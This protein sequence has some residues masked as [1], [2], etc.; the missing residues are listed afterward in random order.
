MSRRKSAVSMFG[1]LAADPAPETDASP[2]PEAPPKRRKAGV[3]GATERTMADIREEREKLLRAVNETQ[4]IVA[5]DPETIDPSPVTDRLPDDDSGSF[6][7]LKA[8]LQSEGQK[9]PILVR[10]HPVDSDRYQI[11]FG[12]RRTRALRE[13]G[14]TVL[15]QVLDY[16]DRDLLVAQGIENA[17]R[18]DLTWIEKALFA[19]RM[20]NAGL[21]PRDILAAL[22]IDHSELSKYRA[23]TK[24][25]PIDLLEAIGRS[26]KAGRPRW[27][28][29]VA[30][31]DGSAALERIRTALAS[32]DLK[33]RRSDDRFAAA[34]AAVS[35]PSERARTYKSRPERPL[36]DFG[37]AKFGSSDVKIAFKGERAE[38][39]RAFLEREL[40]D[41]V[42]RFEK[43]EPKG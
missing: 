8:T 27:R 16:T 37:V 11:V 4:G 13:L 33:G 31:I 24:A 22:A 40:D 41:L 19:S 12:H 20:T 39:F 26:P 32:P 14:R 10:P 30:G 28:D 2:P 42:T 7:A 29:L 21:K 38:A 23:V 15:A 18:Q 17:S 35:E 1:D 3:I 9:V 34:L 25:I 5:L 6:E 43:E 36:G